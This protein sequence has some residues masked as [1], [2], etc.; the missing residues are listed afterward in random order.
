MIG[1]KKVGKNAKILKNSFAIPKEEDAIKCIQKHKEILI[2]KIKRF[3]DYADININNPV[4]V[5]EREK[6]IKKYVWLRGYHRSVCI[7]YKLPEYDFLVKFSIDPR[8]MKM[9]ILT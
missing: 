8:I 5:A 4:A 6:I 7:L 2:D 1:K 3:G 9:I